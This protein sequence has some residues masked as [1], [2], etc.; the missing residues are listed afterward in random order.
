MSLTQLVVSPSSSCLRWRPPI[1]SSSSRW[2]FA[3]TGSRQSPNRRANSR[4]QILSLASS[5]VRLI[6]RGVHLSVGSGFTLTLMASFTLTGGIG[7]LLNLLP[8]D[9]DSDGFDFCFGINLTYNE[10]MNGLRC[11]EMYPMG[12][13]PFDF[14]HLGQ[15]HISLHLGH[16]R[17]KKKL[18]NTKE[19]ASRDNTHS[20]LQTTPFFPDK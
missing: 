17:C 18:I 5:C 10:L 20:N 12:S 9:N 16:L 3:G 8:F 2:D 11:K 6:V 14:L 1:S 7:W 4:I 15:L 13:R 19:L